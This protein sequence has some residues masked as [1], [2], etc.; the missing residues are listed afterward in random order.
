[1]SSVYVRTQ[2]RQFLEDNSNETVINI[3]SAFQEIK[4]LIADNDIQP[5]APW[6]GL[7][8]IGGELLPVSFPATNDQGKYREFGAFALHV[9]EVARLGQNTIESRAQALQDLFLGRRIGSI[10]VTEMTLLNEGPGATLQFEGGYVSGSFFV[11]YQRD[12]DL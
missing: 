4:E 6:L 5:D 7:E 12:L 1:M 3:N 2:I 8:F 11:N 10:I 9:V